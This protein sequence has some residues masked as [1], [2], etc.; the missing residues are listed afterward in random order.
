MAN[1]EIGAEVERLQRSF[2]FA[3]EWQITAAGYWANMQF[4]LGT[5]AAALAAV[6]SGTAFSKQS[7]IAGALAAAAALAAAV[8]ASLR[9]AER[10]EQHQQAAA[11][12]H[13]LAVEARL[14]RGFGDN[15]GNR[16]STDAVKELEHRVLKL[17]A[18]SPWVPR[19]L[20]RKTQAF[21]RDGLRYYDNEGGT[22][23]PSW[24]RRLVI[25]INR[26]IGRS[27]DQSTI[28][29]RDSE[30]RQEHGSPAASGRRPD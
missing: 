26:L 23:R 14:L 13:A 7:T 19:R 29:A 12:Y 15:V 4:F 10:A 18:D 3:A 27:D 9:P 6:S 21:V 5:A 11:Q 25:R 2:E 28:G 8:L 17:D 30:Q 1:N 22:P 16:P 24:W 20:A